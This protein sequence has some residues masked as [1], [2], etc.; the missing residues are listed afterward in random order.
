MSGRLKSD[1]RRGFMGGLAVGVAASVVLAGGVAVAAIPSTSTGLI[2]GCRNVKTGALRV[3]DY[4]AG[5]RCTAKTERLLPWNA[6]GVAGPRGLQG[7]AGGVGATGPVGA[8]GTTGATG[9]TGT[10][11][12]VGTTGPEGTAGTTGPV[13]AAGTTGATGPVGA[14]GGLTKTYRVTVNGTI[15]AD[16]VGSIYSFNATCQPGDIL[17]GGAA[18]AGPY[19][20]QVTGTLFGSDTVLVSL[21]PGQS[22]PATSVL[23][24]TYGV[25]F[26]ALQNVAYSY[27]IQA[28]C[29]DTSNLPPLP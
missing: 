27:Q 3:I 22:Y 8:A 10:T 15:K 16:T 17:L 9:T 2:S 7:I 1:E 20:G 14:T 5:K 23:L 12:P 19:K 6:K 28:T 29:S 25:D 18:S 11:G 13:G 24:E 26:T 4:Q 21:M